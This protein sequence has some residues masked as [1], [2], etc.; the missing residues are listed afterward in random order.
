ML[1]I[2][3][4]LVGLHVAVALLTLV[5]TPYDPAG[6]V[7]GRLSPPSWAHWAGTDRLGRDYF[8][9]VMIGSRIALTVG[10]GA[11]LIGGVIGTVLGLLA[12]FAR[13][14][15][16]DGLAATFDILIAFP[17]LLLAMLIVA[18]SEGASLSTAIIAIG[19]ALS[20]IVGRLV[21]I[22]TKR[23][24]TQDYITAAR[25][26]GAGW[27]RIVLTHV[28]PNILPT[29]LVHAA[30]DAYAL[31]LARVQEVLHAPARTVNWFD[32]RAALDRRSHTLSLLDLRHWLGQP[33]L[34]GPL[35]T[36]V[37]LQRGDS[38][39]GLVVDE[40]RGR[41]EVVIKAL[42]RALRGLPGYAGATLIGDGRLALILDVDALKKP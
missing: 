2:G 35:L 5:W 20:A 17:T 21:R 33:A 12:A 8:T 40:V 28:L 11:V 23:V 18:A 39:F 30:G 7:G 34:D 36:I 27:P 3:C 37:V 9:Q 31:P 15:A 32:G 16:D 4:L 13:G 42:P 24:L 6:M 19:L 38:R 26:S 10:A 25:C 22:L 41:E 29:L 1:V 14:G